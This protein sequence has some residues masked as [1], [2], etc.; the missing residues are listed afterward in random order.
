MELRQGDLENII[1]NALWDMEEEQ[2]EKIDVRDVQSRIVSEHQKWAYTTV[3][4]V[5]DRLSDK[6]LIIRR[7]DGKKFI[8]KTVLARKV[9]AKAAIEKLVKQHFKNSY[10]NMISFINEEFASEQ[11]AKYS[12][13]MAKSAK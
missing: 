10:E 12:K 4:T 11:N 5:L 7:K 6:D 13:A 3:K 8:Y 2:K 9:A 1:L